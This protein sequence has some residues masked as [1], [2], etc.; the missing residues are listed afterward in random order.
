MWIGIVSD[1]HGH[2]AF[3]QAAA[4]MLESFSVE[5]VLH[6]GDIGGSGIV[7]IFS[8]WSTH[9]VFGNTD[10]DRTAL[11]EAIEESGGTCHGELADLQLAGRR[12]GMT[13]GDDSARLTRLIRSQ[14]YDLV[15]HGHTH[16]MKAVTEG[17][18]LVL[19]PGALY[20]AKRHTIAV[21]DL[22]S[23]NYEIITV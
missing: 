11:R 12:I 5:H 20:R 22:A 10:D 6:C 2:E 4:Y 16:Q 18:T 3:A 13:H 21:V 17:K 19:N 14:T 8:A 1:T 23:L 9:Y 15:C 7:R